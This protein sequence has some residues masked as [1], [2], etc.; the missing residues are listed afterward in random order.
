M[1]R[2]TA[3]VTALAGLLVAVVWSAHGAADHDKPAAKPKVAIFPLAGDAKEDLREKVG[4]ALRRKLDR[5][6]AYEVIDGPAMKE[7]ADAA[8]ATVTADTAADVVVKL[9]AD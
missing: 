3:G 9:A 4:F 7:I 8:E 1:G 6:G 2:Q 5:D